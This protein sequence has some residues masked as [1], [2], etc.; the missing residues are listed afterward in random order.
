[1]VESLIAQ[2]RIG[3]EFRSKRWIWSHLL[4]GQFGC[5]SC[6]RAITMFGSFLT[7]RIPSGFYSCQVSLSNFLFRQINLTDLSPPIFDLKTR[8]ARWCA[9]HHLAFVFHSSSPFL[10]RTS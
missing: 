2:L 4:H 5:L 10:V 6:E 1:M 3:A 9:K 8:K 7:S